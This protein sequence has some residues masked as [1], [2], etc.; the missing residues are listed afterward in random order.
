MVRKFAILIFLLGVAPA[1]LAAAQPLG[2]DSVLGL[3]NQAMAPAINK[4]TS[5]AISWLG[6]FATLQFFITNYNL[7]K[8]DGD[9]QSV[10][11]KLA[12]AIG[13]VGICLYIIN[14]GPQ[15]I[16]AVGDQMFS[17]LGL[18]LPSPGTIIAHTIGAVAA[19]AVVAVTIGG[20]GIVGSTT[21]GMLLVY[22][23]LF[24][25]AVGMFFAFKIFMLQLELG[26]VA[27]LSP[28]SFSFLGLN[29]L[30]DQGIAPF[31][32]LLSLI[33]R[34]LL[35]TVILSAFANV[36]EVVKDNVKALH[37][38]SVT[39]ISSSFSTI[40][41]TLLA[42]IGAYVLLAYLIFK[43][44]SIA[45]T[46]ASGSTSMGTGDVAQAAAAGAAVGAAVAT[47]GASAAATAGKVPQ[48]MS[49]F[50]E[51][52]TSGGSVSN[53]SPMGSGGGETPTFAPP[54]PAAL[55]VNGGGSGAAGPTSTAAGGSA[56][57]S[58][59]SATT[60]GSSS[61]PAKVT[62]GRY[63]ANRTDASP[64]PAAAG[65]SK[66]EGAPPKPASGSSRD[67]G[68]G[69]KTRQDGTAG[70]AA[71]ERAEATSAVGAAPAAKQPAT[72]GEAS[73]APASGAPPTA[74]E[75][76]SAASSG[77]SPAPAASGTLAAEGAPPQ[78]GPSSSRN[79]SPGQATRQGRAASAP[80]EAS[81]GADV[82]PVTV[83]P[84]TS[85][86]EASHAPAGSAQQGAEPLPAAAPADS[87]P[88]AGSGQSAGIGGNKSA[89]ES[90]LTK[91]VDHLTSQQGPR[92]PTLGE[93]LGDANRHLAQEQAAVHVS[94]SPHHH[95]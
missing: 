75:A 44:D 66:A 69:E 71:S 39:E 9:I 47:G 18:E 56:A 92:K 57:P 54:A 51:K 38:M 84:A 89:L 53:A 6:V 72:S 34:I 91:L 29:T 49:A 73:Q 80:V 79:V 24:I 78:P 60:A 22:I 88:S 65:A 31:K 10:I 30:R 1:A 41:E 26:L 95:D 55:S 74:G 15:F 42:A 32:A 86:E 85:G 77:A 64:A 33:Y 16:S 13:W 43:S 12:G 25:L 21:A 35:L 68:A 46:L 70:G 76:P 8:T 94:I 17:L 50:M 2:A 63:G 20:V 40:A 87:S 67:A 4:L 62:S 7:L 58:R 45:A 5:R 28:L 37:D 27:M 93:R 90:D 36:S 61:P 14:N 11:A 83:Q 59:P 81:S 23:L 82:D 19:L 48:A 52:M 3:I